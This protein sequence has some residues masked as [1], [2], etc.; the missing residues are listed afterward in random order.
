MKDVIDFLRAN[1]QKPVVL[2]GMMGSGKTHVGGKLASKLELP[3]FDS[4]KIVEEK[5]GCSVSE[6][7]EKFGED[8]FRA[9][10]KR[11]VLETILA[12]GCVLATGGGAVLDD[13]TRS[14]IRDS[15]ISIWL[16]TDIAESLR[17]MEKN[18][19]RP[20]LKGDD[21]EKI[22]RDLMEKRAPYYA[23][24]DIQIE[25]GASGVEKTLE[26]LIKALYAHVRMGSV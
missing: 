10:E 20:L 16:K 2:V 1:L 13:E 3:F 8:K 12:G 6:I 25:T 26:S 11:A 18:D 24:A 22:L 9:A 21:R 15:A 14:A 19:D 17:R 4:D 23:Q 5:A 7:F